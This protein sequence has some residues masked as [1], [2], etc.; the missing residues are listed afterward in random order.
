MTTAPARTAIAVPDLAIGKSH[1]PALVSGGASTYTLDVTNAGDAASSGTVTRDR[2]ARRRPHRRPAPRPAR[3]GPAPAPRAITCTRADALAP[4]DAYPPIRIPVRVV[5]GAP[6]GAISN[7][8][9]VDRGARRRH[10]RRHGHRRGRGL[11]AG[12]RPRADQDDVEHAGERPDALR[13]RRGGRRSRSW[14]PTT[15]PT[16]R[17]TRPSST[18]CPPRCSAAPAPR[19]RGPCDT[20]DAQTVRCDVG[21]LAAGDSVHD[22]RPRPRW[23]RPFPPYPPGVTGD[24]H[25]D[26]QRRVGDRRRP[27]QRHGVLD[28]R[29]GPGHRPRDHEVLRA[30]AP[31]RRRARD[32][33]RDGPQQRPTG[34]RRRRRGPDPG[35]AAG[36]DRRGRPATR[37]APAGRPVPAGAARPAA[38]RD[39]AAG[40]RRRARVHGSPGRLAADSAGTPVT[41]MAAVSGQAAE[42]DFTNNL[43][44]VTFTPGTSALALSKAVDKPDGG[45]RRHHHL[46]LDR[47]RDRR[48]RH[49]GR[50]RDRSAARRPGGRG[51]LPDGCAADAGTVTCRADVIAAGEERA[52]AIPVTRRDGRRGDDG[53]QPRDRDERRHRRRGHSRGRRGGA[54]PAR[55]RCQA[56]AP[57]GE[58]PG[59]PRLRRRAS[60]ARPAPPAVTVSASCA[61]RRRFVIRLR[62]RRGRTIVRA[63]VTA[64]G[65]RIAVA[66][67][68]RR[69]LGRDRRPARRAAGDLPLQPSARSLRGGRTL[70]W[71]RAYRTCASTQAASNRLGDPGAL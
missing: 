55:R 47:A 28:L 46:H 52:F 16:T 51:R 50:R 25:R 24:Q 35:R 11:D 34:D 4:G 56:P 31:G 67:A 41:N 29:H 53:R 43:A 44:S 45:G 2:H 37:P 5:A 32:L 48:R 20:P 70:R 40:G 58:T 9:T 6:P 12:R 23:R 1:S 61:S 59:R 13:A 60:A 21:P 14:S 36:R 19:S 62:E 63:T 66:Q 39:P 68:R 42:E 10:E 18:T 64:G 17:R 38:V 49:A 22:H 7:T 69:P 57:R 65:R 8:A 30:R 3:A 33:H 27:V 71:T 54:R 26:G 15:G